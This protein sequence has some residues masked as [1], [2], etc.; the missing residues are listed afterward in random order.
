MMIL[1]RQEKENLVLDLYYNQKKTYRQIAKIARISP[2]DIGATLNKA[3]NEAERK[4]SISVSSHAYGLFSVGQT[5]INVAINL[6]LREP[7]VTALYLEYCKLKELNSLI[8]IYT[9]YKENIGHIVNLYRSMKAAS[10]GMQ[11]VLNLV[12]VANDDLPGLEQK[13]ENLRREINFIEVQVQNSRA[14]LRELNNQVTEASTSVEYYRSSCRQEVTKL[15]ALR[16]QSM[17]LEAI[18]SQFENNNQE[19]LKIKRIAEEKV[20]SALSDT[21][22]LLKYALLSLVESMKKDPDKSSSLIY[23]DKYPF[24]SSTGDYVSQFHAA[25]DIYGKDLRTPS[26]DW[27]SDDCV[28]MLVEEAEKVY[29]NLAKECVGGTVANYAAST[30]SLPSLPQPSDEK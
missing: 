24:A 7:E 25:F 9:E 14:I 17:K 28:A 19:Y 20:H 3:S 4:Q 16:Q 10:I 18:V 27:Y 5:T 1:N 6:N 12:I 13:C 11:D 8:Q 26:V 22:A 30:S 2:R 23:N 29:N 15:E 21:K